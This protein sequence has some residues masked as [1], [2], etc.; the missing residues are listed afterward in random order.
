MR[1]HHYELVMFAY[2]ITMKSSCWW[3]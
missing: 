3:A 1:L 2:Y